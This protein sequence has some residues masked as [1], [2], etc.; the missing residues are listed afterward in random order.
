MKSNEPSTLQAL[1][2][3]KE[4]E[5]IQFKEAQNRFGFDEA[6]KI[7]CALSNGGGG[8]LVFGITDKRPRRVVGSS[9]FPQPERDR[10]NLMNKLRVQVDFELFEHEN[11]RVLAFHVAGRPYGLPIQVDGI[12]WWY[13]GDSLQ[14][15]PQ[16]KLREIYEEVGHD[17]SGDVCYGATMYDLHEEALENFRARWYE[18]SKLSRIKNASK[19]QLLRD[20]EAL[21]D[22]G[23]TYAA[24]ILFGSHASLGKYLPQSEIVF[25]YRSKEASGPAQQR[26]NFRIGFFA[27]YE[28]LWE[29]INL[30]NDKQHYQEGL[31]IREIATFNER[32]VREALLNAISHRNYQLGGSVFIKQYPD[33]LIIENPGGL[34]M[35]I[36]LENMLDRQSPRNR[37]ITEILSLC[38]LVER[39]GQGMNL[40][41]E[42][43][44]KEAKALPEFTGSDANFLRIIL[45][46]LVLDKE[47]LSVIGRIGEERLETMSTADLLVVHY[48]FQGE[49]LSVHLK[50]RLKRLVEMGIVEHVGRGKYVLARAIF[51]AAGRPGRH[52]RLSGLDRNTNKSL[53]I[54]H[55]RSSGKQGAP[56]RELHEVLPGHS[57]SQLQV[58]LRELR[59]DGQIHSIGKTRGAKWFIGSE[60][61]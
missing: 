46:G 16:E 58:L 28:Q 4:G 48:L 22:E 37:R 42:Q 34:P 25:E 14:A 33:R 53:I 38:G 44:I 27:C 36:T 30:R 17:F 50:T 26:E 31:F 57:N 40:I 24:L 12:P 8:K 61:E 7:C 29:L 20:C 1:L 2:T 39:S 35:G 32:V 18:K 54:Q 52:T 55:L 21:T 59:R 56:L 47:I 5:N 6:A 51:S 19:E 49:K 13:V 9:A 60:A 10:L 15:M 3:A 41:Y 11:K 23:L 45:H 43:S